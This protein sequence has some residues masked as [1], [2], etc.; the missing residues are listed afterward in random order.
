MDARLR[1]PGWWL[2][3][4]IVYLRNTVIYLRNNR[5][6]SWLGIEPE[7]ES[8]KVQRPN[9]YTTEPPRRNDMTSKY[10]LLT[11]KQQISVKQ[12][13]KG[14]S[15]SSW[16]TTRMSCNA[17][18]KGTL[19]LK[20]A[21]LKVYIFGKFL[22]QKRSGLMPSLLRYFR[23]KCAERCRRLVRSFEL[24]QAIFRIAGFHAKNSTDS[25]S[26]SVQRWPKYLP[27]WCVVI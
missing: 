19:H 1:W 4:K 14:Y 16:P 23:P 11:I 5:A 26:V 12:I 13:F 25:T 3:P 24:L 21:G 15:P 27:Y 18:I 2:Y 6:V 9:H 7:T 17:T 20:L 8:H 22:Q 10:K